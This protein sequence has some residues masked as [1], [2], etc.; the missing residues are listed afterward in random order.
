[1]HTIGIQQSPLSNDEAY[2]AL[3]ANKTPLAPDSRLFFV[4]SILAHG[5]VIFLIFG[6]LSFPVP[7]DLPSQDVHKKELP[8]IQS[9]LYFSPTP[10]MQ[11]QELEPGVSVDNDASKKPSEPFVQEKQTMRSRLE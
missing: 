10:V 7:T 5:T 4:L 8:K 2:P 9:Y 6:H 3:I 1:L 11:S